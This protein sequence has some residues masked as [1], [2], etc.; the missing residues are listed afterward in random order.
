MRH[1][2]DGQVT[3]LIIGYILV[4]LL[5]ISVMLAA[6]AVYI[7]HKKLLSLAD[8]AAVTAAD[9]YGLGE[10]RT[11]TENPAP[12]LDSGAVRD[13]AGRYLQRTNAAARFSTLALDPGTGAPDS[14]TARVVLTAVVHPPVVS[15]LLPD[16]VS[17]TAVADARSNLRR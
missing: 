17:I 16:G 1:A 5:V 9:S 7:E 8:G 3:V 13:S 6:S 2:E 4:S 12:S 11:D 14:R 15:F 10:V